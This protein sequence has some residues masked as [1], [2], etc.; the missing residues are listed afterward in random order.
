MPVSLFQEVTI[1]CPQCGHEVP[2][3]VALVVHADEHPDRVT[4]ARNG[5]LHR[6]TSSL[7]QT[8]SRGALRG[9]EASRRG[10]R[11]A[12]APD[13]ARQEPRPPRMRPRPWPP[14]RRRWLRRLGRLTMTR[15][16]CLAT[17]RGL[18]A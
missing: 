17:T 1:P 13:A 6:E 18:L 5:A 9:R 4:A 11:R 12:P 15:Q 8:P 3:R 10:A 2:A 14:P 7:R 16:E